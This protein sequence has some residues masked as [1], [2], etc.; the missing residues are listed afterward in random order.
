MF[1]FFISR[2]FIEVCIALKHSGRIKLLF[3]GLGNLRCYFAVFIFIVSTFTKAIH[4]P[5]IRLI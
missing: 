5:Y 2:L 4:K 1:L 3:S